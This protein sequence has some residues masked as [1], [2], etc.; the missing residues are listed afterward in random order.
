MD[1]TMQATD[2]TRR[3]RRWRRW[4]KWGA[5]GL[6]GFLVVSQTVP[7]GRGHS[8]PA[9]SA[10]PAWDSPTTQA[11]VQTACGDCHSSTTKWLWYS[12]IAPVSWLVQNDV[13]G[14]RRKLNFSE[15]DKPQV[16]ASE[17]I[18][19]IRSGGMPPLQYTLIHRGAGLSQAERL[20]LIQGLEATFRASP[21]VPGERGGG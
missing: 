6:V 3:P 18:E 15:W 5:L 7:Y 16:D 13:D 2:R 1:P 20:Q 12:N 14:G 17:I 8:N 21:P 9:V 11:M 4:L 10:E 19:Q